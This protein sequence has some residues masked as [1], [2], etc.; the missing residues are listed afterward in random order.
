MLR[1]RRTSGGAPSQILHLFTSPA[2]CPYDFL[3]PFVGE[4]STT[5][6]PSFPVLIGKYMQVVHSGST[7]CLREDLNVL[8]PPVRSGGRRA[9][10][11]VKDSQSGANTQR[12]M[13]GKRSMGGCW[14]AEGRPLV[15]SAQDP[16]K[17]G[18][19]F[20]ISVSHPFLCREGT[21][22]SAIVACSLARG[23]LEASEWEAWGLSHPNLPLT[24][25]NLSSPWHWLQPFSSPASASV[26]PFITP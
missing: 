21:P 25:W 26:L 12:C 4:Y 11:K 20:L 17:F 3:C 6:S 16:L 13:C 7:S 24:H 18:A 23:L 1:V 15:L 22:S 2:T 10:E 9:C 5:H 8:Q 19:S 14:W